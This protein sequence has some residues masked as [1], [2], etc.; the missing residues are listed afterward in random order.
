MKRAILFLLTASMLGG[1]LAGCAPGGTSPAAPTQSSAA[2]ADTGT[3]GGTAAPQAPADE[4]KPVLKHLMYNTPTDPNLEP[5]ARMIEEQTGY[6]IEYFNLPAEGADDKM[7]LDLASGVDYDIVIINKTPFFSLATKGALLP[8]DDLL[9]Q[10]GPNVLSAI[11]SDEVFRGDLWAAGKVDGTVVGIPRFDAYYLG[12]GT[13]YTV[14][15]VEKAG[16][17]ISEEPMKLSDF[18]E[19]LRK[20]K[21]AN[22]DIIPY[23]GS[24]AYPL[25]FTQPFGMTAHEWQ[26][27]EGKTIPRIMHPRIKDYLATL[28]DLY[29][30]GLLDPEWPVNKTENITE[31]VSSGKAAFSWQGWWN[32][33]TIN[34]AIEKNTGS[35]VDYL[36]ILTDENGGYVAQG[37]L[38]IGSYVTIPKTSKNPEHA[39]KYINLRADPAI[40]EKCFLGNEGE[41][42][43]IREDGYFPIFPKFT[44]WFNGH[45]FTLAADPATYTSLWLCRLRK[46]ET[47]AAS[48]ARMNRPAKDTW[49]NNALG[50]APPLAAVSKYQQS[51]NELENAFVI[52]C[53]V[54]TKSVDDYD[55][56]LSK[57][58]SEGGQDMVSDVDSYMALNPP[59]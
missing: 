32:A 17:Q 53:I 5:P 13:T 30:Q 50:M 14:D 24:G 15:I 20:V 8:L 40:F 44:E 22:P 27:V 47:V 16:A 38:Q 34:D 26:T 21:A 59:T 41:H 25:T 58:L 55:A 9:A 10:Y 36:N 52:E 57:W 3:A 7:A 6:T 37:N 31:K 18:I 35:K 39:M 54:G 29:A 19:V 33:D 45:Y 12:G 56:F 46:S 23:T 48:F 51:L 42:F 11:K 49:A 1:L 4:E 2:P 43:E 28:S